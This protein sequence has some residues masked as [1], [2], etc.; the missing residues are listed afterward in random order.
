M[1]ANS[2]WFIQKRNEEEDLARGTSSK[3]VFIL[4]LNEKECGYVKQALL[5]MPSEITAFDHVKQCCGELEKQRCDLLIV[6][7]DTLSTDGIKLLVEVK[8]IQP[9]AQLLVLS[10]QEEGTILGWFSEGLT[11]LGLPL[12]EKNLTRT[13]SAALNGVSE[14]GPPSP[15]SRREQDILQHLLDGKSNQETAF[16]LHRSVRTIEFH[17]NNIMQKMRASSFADLVRKGI[18]MG[19]AS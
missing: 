12:I 4:S 6:D 7:I 9:H 14:E 3:R 11:P 15:L 19:L 8:M 2:P 10:S 5:T 18:R 1:R 17:R 13:I 16:I